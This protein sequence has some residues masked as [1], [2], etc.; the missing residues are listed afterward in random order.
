M[1]KIGVL[2]SPQPNISKILV[3]SFVPQNLQIIFIASLTIFDNSI[4][5]LQCRNAVH[6]IDDSTNSTVDKADTPTWGQDTLP[7]QRVPHKILKNAKSK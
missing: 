7:T 5:L 1:L 6:N 2:Y 3:V 4:V